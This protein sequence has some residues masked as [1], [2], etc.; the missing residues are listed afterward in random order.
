MSHHCKYC[1]G[2]RS[3]PHR[4]HRTI[5]Q[6]AKDMEVKLVGAGPE[7]RQKFLRK[8][9]TFRMWPDQETIQIAD[10]WLIKGKYSKEAI[11]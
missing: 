6:L 10:D 4:Q 5:D 2:K 7:V 8:A 1:R 11:I 9:A 3:G